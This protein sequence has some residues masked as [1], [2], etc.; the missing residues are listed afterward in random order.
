MCVCV[1]VCG[2][3]A[4]KELHYISNAYRIL[5]SNNLQ[6]AS[7]TALVYVPPVSNDIPDTGVPCNMPLYKN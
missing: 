3:L 5:F 6:R 7:A 4:I 2:T 1:C